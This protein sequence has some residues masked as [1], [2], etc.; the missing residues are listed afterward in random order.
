MHLNL[1]CQL[2]SLFT[3]FAVLIYCKSVSWRTQLLHVFSVGIYGILNLGWGIS[4]KNKKYF[5][6]QNLELLEC[7]KIWYFILVVCD[8]C[9]NYHLYICLMIHNVKYFSRK[10]AFQWRWSKTTFCQ[11]RM[12][13]GFM[14]LK[15]N[16]E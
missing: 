12:V 16:P 1:N 6:K 3:Q 11:A 2:E 5:A 7:I 14:Q 4:P 8:M 9:I 15:E 13:L 10:A